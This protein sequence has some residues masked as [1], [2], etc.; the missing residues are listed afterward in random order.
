MW[1]Q[2]FATIE[3][4]GQHRF[5]DAA[6]IRLLNNIRMGNATDEDCATLGSRA[7]AAIPAEADNAPVLCTRK[8]ASAKLPDRPHSIGLNNQ[9]YRKLPGKEKVF[10]CKP[11]RPRHM[12]PCCARVVRLKV[13]CV[14][15]VNTNV[16]KAA[17]IVT[18]RRGLVCR[19]EESGESGA[20]C[21][22]VDWFRQG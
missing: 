20:P 4:R 18:G 21:P 7:V 13:G 12:P 19:F 17:G 16:D 3:L 10:A 14:V 9:R 5:T 2:D 15:R 6:F 22:V 8:N 1:P 11:K